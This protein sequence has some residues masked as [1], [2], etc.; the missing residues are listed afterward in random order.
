M[1]EFSFE[2]KIKL[3]EEKA[4]IGD[5]I[6]KK[7]KEITTFLIIF[8]IL[9][10]SIGVFLIDWVGAGLSKDLYLLLWAFSILLPFTFK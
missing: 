1:G 5:E 7:N 6:R 9:W 8:F 2:E 10:I 3:R 4:R